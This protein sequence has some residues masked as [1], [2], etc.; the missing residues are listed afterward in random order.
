MPLV[1]DSGRLGTTRRSRIAFD[2]HLTFLLLHFSVPT[3]TNS[4]GSD[5]IPRLPMSMESGEGISL[6][7]AAQYGKSGSDDASATNSQKKNQGLE[8]QVCEMV[9]KPQEDS[10]TVCAICL[11]SVG[12]YNAYLVLL[13]NRSQLPR[14]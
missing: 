11:E 13:I 6:S 9:M 5:P 3:K 14:Y 4:F 7:L 10:Q 2:E 12:M 8:D 1:Q